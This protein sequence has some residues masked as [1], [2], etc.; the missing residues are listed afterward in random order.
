MPVRTRAWEH[1]KQL[2]LTDC[3]GMAVSL[4]TLGIAVGCRHHPASIGRW[5]PARSRTSDYRCAR[6]LLF[7]KAALKS[8][9]RGR[10]ADRLDILHFARFAPSRTR[11]AG[12]PSGLPC[13]PKLPRE[14]HFLVNDEPR[15]VKNH[16]CG[17]TLRLASRRSAE[18]KV[19]LA[20]TH[21]PQTSL[22]RDPELNFAF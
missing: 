18:L 20:S 11:H 15:A 3:A 6:K 9:R 1:A 10:E 22:C 13:R 7:L 12:V 14:L 5:A 21:L 16:Y 8:A 19:G 4:V 17:Q 2:R